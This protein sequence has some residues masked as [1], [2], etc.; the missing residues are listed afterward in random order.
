MHSPN[1]RLLLQTLA[2]GGAMGL[3]GCVSA[4][5]PLRVGSIVFPGYEPLFLARD[6]GWLHSDQVRLI[7][8]LSSQDS[9]RA[10]AS[11]QLEAAMLTLDEVLSGISEG[12]DLRVVAI[13]DRSEGADAVVVHPRVPNDAALAGLTLAYEEGAVGALMLA[14]FLR[15]HKLKP[16]HFKRVPTTLMESAAALRSGS[17]DVVVTGEPWLS[18]LEAF[19][20]R[21][22][23]DSRAIPW[24]I[25]D[26]L[27]VRA[28]VLTS[29][30][31]HIRH[32]VHSH[33]S[34]LGFW[35]RRPEEAARRVAPRLDL[36]VEQVATVLRGLI[37]PDLDTTR[38]W[39]QPGSELARQVEALQ[40]QMVRDGL[41]SRSVPTGTLF[42]PRFLD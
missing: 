41:L 1:R 14:E 6:L 42:D 26:L 40:Q 32:A 25:I 5:P 10:L 33:Y 28:D 12:L 16:E 38:R 29:H 37:Q 30:G 11:K 13:L 4:P 2:L 31:H 22:L 23:F 18:Q 35:Q 8:L 9:L 21:R 39:F 3:A 15:A 34:A 20:A 36:P 24:R 7:E 19:G 27:A 17:A